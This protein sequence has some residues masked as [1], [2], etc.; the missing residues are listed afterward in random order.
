VLG[1][2]NIGSRSLDGV[3]RI[4]GTG[5]EWCSLIWRKRCNAL[6]LAPFACLSGVCDFWSFPVETP[7]RFTLRPNP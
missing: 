7:R 3:E 5:H 4:D 6:R 1:P 2:G